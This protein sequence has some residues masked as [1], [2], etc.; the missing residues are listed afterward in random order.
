[1]SEKRPKIRNISL[2]IMVGFA[3]TAPTL[4]QI[5][6]AG[7][8]GGLRPSM[9]PTQTAPSGPSDAMRDRSRDRVDAPDMD[10]LRIRDRDLLYLGN[11]DRLKIFDRNNDKKI[12]WQEFKL[13]HESAYDAINAAGN[14]GFYLHE[15]QAVRLGPGPMAKNSGPRRQRN[16]ERAQLRKAKRFQLMDGDGNGM[17]TR[18]EFMKFGE[19][20]YLDADAN[21]D[22]K[23]S[24]GELQQFHR[25]R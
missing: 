3:L 2:A 13:W 12:D 5:G 22:G 16:E 4:A 15:F 25:G 17:V 21:N 11:R 23:L 8:A 14:E 6:G 20:N 9:P 1:M 19:L 24:F 7:G 18:T 10:R